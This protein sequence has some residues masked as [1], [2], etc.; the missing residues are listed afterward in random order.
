MFIKGDSKLYSILNSYSDFIIESFDYNTDIEPYLKLKKL[1]ENGN[2][3]TEFAN[4]Y[5][6]YYRLHAA[7][8]SE[9]FCKKYFELLYSCYANKRISIF[10]IMEKLA[11]IECNENGDKK[12]H[13]SFAS[14]LVHTVDNSKPIYD[15]MIA[16][17]YFFPEIKY[18]WIAEKK[19]E[20]YKK[21]YNFLIYEY[22]RVQNEKLIDKTVHKLM[23]KYPNINHVNPVK[24]IDWI[25]WKYISLLKSGKIRD[26]IIVYG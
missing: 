14:K 8:L 15:S 3:D 4:E 16:Q 19:I 10:E 18:N 6:R 1:Y 24:I 26:K 25:I 22:E 9:P 7:R 17:F 20:E 5:N 2:I 21:A 12:L 23:V 11:E 13:F